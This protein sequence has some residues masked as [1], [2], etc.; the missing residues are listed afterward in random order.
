MLGSSTNLVKK[1]NLLQLNWG[2]ILAL[3]VFFILPG[4][5]K[6][7]KVE[8][9]E[10][11]VED[12]Y[13]EAI[14]DLENKKF[15]EA[16]EKFDDVERQHPYSIWASKA[17][18]ISSFAQYQNNNYDDALISLDRFIQ[19]HPAH[20]DIA[21]AY[22]LKALCYYE[23]ISDVVRDQAMTELA[24]TAFKE[25][26]IRFP[27]SKYTRDATLKLDLTNDHLAGKEMEIGRYY[28]KQGHFLAAINRFRNVVGKFETTT[29]VA[30]ALHRL[31]ECYRAL[32]L[33]EDAQ[34]TAAVLGHNFPESNWYLDSYQ[35]LK[36]TPVKKIKEQEGPWYEVWKGW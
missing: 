33:A 16:T 29:H 17:Q 24:L 31:T 25:L 27:D 15:K 36:G 5:A 13:N 14:D 30:E 2:C 11:P 19:L 3:A 18:L 28:H 26:I 12:L 8:H 6:E 10:R 7:V 23:Q 35:M 21:Y 1:H 20:K 22:Y 4:C 32:G 9:K 34:K